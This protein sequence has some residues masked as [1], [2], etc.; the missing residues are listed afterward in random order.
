[1]RLNTNLKYIH[2]NSKIINEILMVVDDWALDNPEFNISM[3]DV[4]TYYIQD[5]LIENTE[6]D[7]V[8]ELGEFNLGS[9]KY[10]L[11]NWICN[12]PFILNNVQS[13]KNFNIQFPTRNVGKVFDF[14]YK[15]NIYFIQINSLERNKHVGEY[16]TPDNLE[17]ILKNF[18]NGY[19]EFIKLNFNGML[20]RYIERLEF[21]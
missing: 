10:E 15:K 12:L 3:L 5:S 21:I 13:C 8:I 14:E 19:I 4:I 17:N 1:M 18:K 9:Y 2:L 20:P 6:F 7:F 11:V 16:I